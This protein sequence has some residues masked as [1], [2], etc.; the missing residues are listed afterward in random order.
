MMVLKALTSLVAHHPPEV[1]E[2]K[3]YGSWG[4]GEELDLFR[5]VLWSNPHLC[6]LEI[7]SSVQRSAAAAQPTCKHSQIHQQ[8]SSVELG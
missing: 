4:L 5:K 8:S 7:G 6:C 1:V 3:E 2:N